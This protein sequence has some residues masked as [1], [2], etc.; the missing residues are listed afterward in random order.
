MEKRF[1]GEIWNDWFSG[2]SFSFWSE[3][4]FGK[5]G[6]M[7]KEFWNLTGFIDLLVS[8]INF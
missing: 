1:P 2:D 6:W 8:E 3:V 7:M 5:S 4:L